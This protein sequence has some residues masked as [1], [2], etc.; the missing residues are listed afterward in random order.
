MAGLYHA[1]ARHLKSIYFVVG[2]DMFREIGVLVKYCA[3]SAPQPAIVA[4]N[5][6]IGQVGACRASHCLVQDAADL[7]VQFVLI[8]MVSKFSTFH[9]PAS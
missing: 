9:E 8:Q 2:C 6:S 1:P 5:I 3:C 4:I 7:R